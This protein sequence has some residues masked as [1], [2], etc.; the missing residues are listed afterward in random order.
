MKIK[1]EQI[2]KQ[3]KTILKFARNEVEYCLD[4]K[5]NEINYTMLAE[6]VANNF[7]I[8]EGDGYTIP[9]ELFELMLSVEA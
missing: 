6:N 1:P 7:D 3:K 2:Y 8:Y 5:T 4:R 9:E